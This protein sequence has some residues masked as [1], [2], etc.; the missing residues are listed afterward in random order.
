MPT[1]YLPVAASDVLGIANDWHTEAVN[2]GKPGFTIITNDSSGFAKAGRRMFGAGMLKMVP[3][4]EKLY[5]MIHGDGNNGANSFEVSGQRANGK[6]RGYTPENL[7]HHLEKEGL[8]KAHQDLRLAACNGG[9]ADSAG[10]SFAS[11][12]KLWMTHLGFYNMTVYAY[13]GEILNIRAKFSDN[14][15]HKVTDLGGGGGVVHRLSGQR[16]AF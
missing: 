14:S 3:S 13:Q 11:I 5:V 4:T 1:I 16:V 10:D 15:F 2:A 12:L 9:R 7:A 6:W 8:S